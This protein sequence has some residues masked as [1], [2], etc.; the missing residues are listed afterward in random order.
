MND[1]EHAEQ[2]AKELARYKE[3]KPWRE[4]QT[5]V[6]AEED[7]EESSEEKPSEEAPAEEAEDTTV[8]APAKPVGS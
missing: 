7:D 5:G 4:R 3:N 8:E 1:P 2:L 6:E